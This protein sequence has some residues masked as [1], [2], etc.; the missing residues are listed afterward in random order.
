[1]MDINVHSGALMARKTTGSR[2]QLGEPYASQLTAFCEALVGKPPEIRVVREA[3]EAFI[4]ERIG[5]DRDLRQRYENALKI[6][7]GGSDGDNV[8]VLPKGK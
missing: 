8:V 1:M 7:R 3:V 6:Q 5:A 2:M 4:R